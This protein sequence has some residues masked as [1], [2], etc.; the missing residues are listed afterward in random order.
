M[1]YEEIRAAFTVLSFGVFVGIVWW[2]YS[3]G[4][5][6]RFDEAERLA[7]ADDRAL[8]LGNENGEGRP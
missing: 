2:A 6:A 1:G 5:Q 7:L 4:S 3:K 8:P